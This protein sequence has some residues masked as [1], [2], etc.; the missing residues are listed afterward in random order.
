MAVSGPQAQDLD[1]FRREQRV[2]VADTLKRQHD[3]KVNR[4]QT[5][6]TLYTNVPDQSYYRQWG[7]SHR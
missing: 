1:A 2:A 6:K 7:T 5:L 3:T 4:D